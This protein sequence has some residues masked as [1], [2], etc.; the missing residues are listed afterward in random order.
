LLTVAATM[1]SGTVY[2]FSVTRLRPS[3]DGGAG[4]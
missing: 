1:S 2:P 4:N 3:S